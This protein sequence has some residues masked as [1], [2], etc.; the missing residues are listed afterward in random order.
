MALD[1]KGGVRLKGQEIWSLL[2]VIE[3]GIWSLLEVIE[4]G[5][6]SLL[7][8]IEV[9]TWSGVLFLVQ[10]VRSRGKDWYNSAA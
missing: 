8:V 6:W 7:E 4:V 3:V 10:V 1:S 9:D 5:V 2:E